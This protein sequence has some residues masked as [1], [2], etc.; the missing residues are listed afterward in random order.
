MKQATETVAEGIVRRHSRRCASTTKRCS[1]K[2]AYLASVYSKRDQ[3]RIRKTFGNFAEAKSWRADAIAKMGRG[4]LRAP[5]KTKLEDAAEAWLDGA[6]AGAILNRSRR[7][8]KPSVIRSYERSLRLRILPAFG[9]VRLADL[10]RHAIQDFAD[11]LQAEGLN[12]ST[13]RNT[14]NPL[15]A[16]YRRALQR[17]EVGI[18]PT[19]GLELDA[20][21]GKRDRVEDAAGVAALLAALPDDQ[22]AVWATA[23]H[24][25]LRR[26]ELRA[27]RWRDVELPVGETGRIHVRQGW[28][29]NE[30][31][32]DVK[33]KAGRRTLPVNA[34]LRRELAAHKLRTGGAPDAFVFGSAPSVT[35]VPSTVRRRALAAWKLAELE[36]IGLHEARHTFGTWQA[37]AGV[38]IE[39]LKVLMG[40]SSITQTIDQYGHLYPDALDEAAALAD[41]F[42]LAEA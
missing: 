24:A 19:V 3:R 2:P 6:R 36:P 20:A 33:S 9:R 27:L 37:R 7:A 5:T 17:G 39:V 28:D 18:N 11:C 21:R 29:D 34:L 25:G 12:P 23:F 38:R 4:E 22:R 31:E 40:H 8:Y 26:G 1:C 16:I 13:V 30:G 42:L 41:A 15:Q 14:L 32:I 35:F 10:D